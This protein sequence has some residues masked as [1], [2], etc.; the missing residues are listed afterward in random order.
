MVLSLFSGVQVHEWHAWG[1]PEDEACVANAA[2]VRHAHCWPLL[3]D[4][5]DQALEWL[6]GLE[7]PAGLQVS[8]IA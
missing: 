7:G 5:L 6:R 3:L 2:M 4:P 8:C 1:L